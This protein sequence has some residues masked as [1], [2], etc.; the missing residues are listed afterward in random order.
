MNF[1]HYAFFSSSSIF[2][3]LCVCVCLPSFFLFIIRPAVCHKDKS[4]STHRANYNTRGRVLSSHKADAWFPPPRWSLQH[5]FYFM[6]CMYG[7]MHGNKKWEVPVWRQAPLGRKNVRLLHF[8]SS[9]LKF[10]YFRMWWFSTHRKSCEVQ[11]ITSLI[12][13]RSTWDFWVN[14]HWEK[15][16][17]ERENSCNQPPMA[18]E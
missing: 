13:S 5:A 12:C 14:P 11:N 2:Y 18:Q 17:M 6:L 4:A 1:R 7:N 3:S 15:T 8:A 9:V 10:K 16:K